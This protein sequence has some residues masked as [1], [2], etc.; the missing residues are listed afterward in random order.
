M[1]VSKD[2][3]LTVYGTFWGGGKG[4]YTYRNDVFDLNKISRKMA[5]KDVERVAGDF[6]SIQNFRL[7]ETIT[8]T[9]QKVLLE[10]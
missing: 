7:M 4:Y 1:I 3:E 2:L 6:E 5:R 9:K 8:T 10:E